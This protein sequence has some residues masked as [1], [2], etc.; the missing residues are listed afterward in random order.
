MQLD[1]RLLGER[2]QRL[3]LHPLGETGCADGIEPVAEQLGS[4]FAGPAALAVADAQVDAGAGQL[5]RRIADHMVDHDVLVL[6]PEGAKA[7][8][9]PE[10]G[11]RGGCAESDARAP[12]SLT[13]TAASRGNLGEAFADGGAQGLAFR[14][15][16]DAAV[17]TQEEGAAELCLQRLDL[18]ADRAGSDVEL[19]CRLL[20]GEMSGCR[21]E[22]RQAAEWRQVL[23]AA[24]HVRMEWLTR[25]DCAAGCA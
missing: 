13:Q 22:D 4:L 24:A 14:S 9:Q 3:S 1:E 11:D 18:A 20:E 25:P 2:I 15:E 7:W 17:N 23:A 19:P 5:P 8:H 10:R 6:A 12:L 21:L 16:A